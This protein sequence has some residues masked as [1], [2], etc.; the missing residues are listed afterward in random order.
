M[1][2]KVIRLILS[3]MIMGIIIPD[4]PAGAGEELII[5]WNKSYY[6]E[7]D[8][9]LE[10]VVA[11]WEKQSGTKVELNF[12]TTEDIPKKLI[13][14]IDARN[15]PDIAFGHVLDLQYAPKWAYDGLLEPV[16]D[17]VLPLKDKWMPV[18]LETTLLYDGTRKQREHYGV[19]IEQQTVHI[20][21]WASLL[22]QVGLG[23]DDIP[24]EW[25]AFWNFWCDAQKKLRKKGMRIYG[26][27][28]T[29]SS[30]SIDTFFHFNM[31]L[32]AHGVTFMDK[33]GKLLVDDP[34]VRKGIEAALEDFTKPYIRGCTPPGA[35]NWQ[36]PDN[37][38]NFLN[39]ITLMTAN[40][41]LSIPASQ[42]N[43]NPDNYF[44]NI[45]TIEWPDG[46]G[47][48]PMVYMTAVKPAL[49]FRDS[50]HKAAAKSFLKFLVR[51][52]NL[53]P[54]VKGSFGRWFPVMKELAEDPYWKGTDDPHR[55]VHFSQYTRHKVIPF[56]QVC[57]YKYA[58]VQAENLWGKA[59]GRML[60]DGWSARKSLDE[61]ITRM[62]KLLE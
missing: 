44:K 13:V 27:G 50:K 14:A 58:A 20:H 9:K 34:A 5:W 4:V 61:L 17:V 62:K 38:L 57:N 53:G 48:R 43:V 45:R 47:G 49:I 12:L 11:E 24:R 18:A 33:A 52:E 46:P 22:K 7:E 25:A 28:Q 3:V 19:P 30:V 35:I 59:A 42:F 60:V 16:G 56:Q 31:F 39:Q 26:I 40:P 55:S 21:Y 36:D 1:R 2:K 23:E 6:P 37:N 8:R 54:Y 10:E 32:N 41:T 15:P 29:L 51:P